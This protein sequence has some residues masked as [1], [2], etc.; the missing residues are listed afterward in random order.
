MCVCVCGYVM[1]KRNRAYGVLINASLD[2]YQSEDATK[3]LNATQSVGAISHI[4]LVV[5]SVF[6]CLKAFTRQNVEMRSI[7]LHVIGMNF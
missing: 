2:S 3:R 6:R 5:F 1:G 4:I 7:I